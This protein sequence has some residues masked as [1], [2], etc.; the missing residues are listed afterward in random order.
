V[1]PRLDLALRLHEA[2]QAGP[3]EL[4]LAALQ[5]TA[6]ATQGQR[7]NRLRVAGRG[8]VVLQVH[9]ERHRAGHRDTTRDQ[10]DPD[11]G[12]RVPGR[13][14]LLDLGPV[15]AVAGEAHGRGAQGCSD[16]LRGE[17]AIRHEFFLISTL[18]PPV[19]R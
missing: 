16:L 2:E 19:K 13:Q 17:R 15:R 12:G 5:V 6:A 3:V 9:P 10:E 4:D 7:S 14:E 8:H 18:T 1:A 11:P